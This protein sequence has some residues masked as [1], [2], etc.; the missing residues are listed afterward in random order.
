MAIATGV[1]M[2]MA[3]TDP[4]TITETAMPI[5][6]NGSWCLAWHGVVYILDDPR[7]HTITD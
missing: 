7:M 4:S 1:L 2:A 3:T 6:M 5:S